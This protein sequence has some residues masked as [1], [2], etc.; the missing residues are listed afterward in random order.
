MRISRGR[1]AEDELLD[2]KGDA[3][4]TFLDGIKLKT[5]AGELIPRTSLSMSAGV[6]V[7]RV[8]KNRATGDMTMKRVIILLK[9][10]ISTLSN[11]F[12]HTGLLAS[13][14]PE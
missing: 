10:Y 9:I 11:R 13:A 4:S 12:V 2:P 5:S 1:E 8:W 7:R 6:L 14:I 3:W